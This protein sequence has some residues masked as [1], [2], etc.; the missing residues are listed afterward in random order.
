MKLTVKD[1]DK[2]FGDNHVLK[3]INL[4]AY[5]G[6]ALGILGRNGAGKTTTIRI[7]MGVFD[8]DEGEI[9]VDDQKIDRNKIGIGYLPEERGLYPKKVIIDQLLY[10]GELK[11]M[12]KKE[13]MVSA[14]NYI[15][16]FCDNISILNGGEI[17]VS[18]AIKEIKRS[19]ER[20]K[21]IV[22]SEEIN[23]VEQHLQGV[24]DWVR[25]RARIDDNTLLITLCSAQYKDKLLKKL[26]E[27]ELAI[28]EFKVYEPSL[29]DIFVEHTEEGI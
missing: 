10:F 25:E 21:I 27:K 22:V 24:S 4:E 3:N 28:D 11:G 23:E 20:N 14:E 9:L 19:Y 2:R 29:N 26:S 17:V 6:K 13:A 7:I 8:G 1:I 12:S 5:S 16:E 18:G 15:E